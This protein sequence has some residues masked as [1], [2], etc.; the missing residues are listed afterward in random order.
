MRILF[1]TI[2]S[3]IFTLTTT[4]QLTLTYEALP[5]PGD[6]FVMWYDTNPN[7]DIGEA[8]P[9]EQHFDFS[10]LQNS[11][12][13]YSAY[14][15][16]AD[17]EVQPFFPSSNLY[18]YGPAI[19]YGGPGTPLPGY[20]EGWMLF[21]T[22]ETGMWV[23][24]YKIDD[25]NYPAIPQTPA[26]QL[27]RTPCTYNDVFEQNSEWTADFN[28]DSSDADTV[29][30]SFVYSKLSVDAWGT[31]DTPIEED[32]A[33]LRINEYRETIDSVYYR[34][35]GVT[36]WKDEFKRDT[37]NVYSYYSTE[38][39]HPIVT[40]YCKPNDEVISAE[41]LQYSLLYN[42]IPKHS[43]ASYTVY[44]NPSSHSLQI[45]GLKE[46]TSYE[47]YNE[48]GKV[49]ISGEIQTGETIDISSLKAGLYHLSIFNNNSSFSTKVIKQ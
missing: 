34:M 15:I 25:D 38:K 47:V 5:H 12:Q 19:L 13:K 21:R 29:Y 49:V 39:R 30:T 9:L 26:L 27:V 32:I 4:A 48:L 3:L 24:G 10:N 45:K 18:T 17:S 8:S 7:I 2:S 36:V 20:N 1:L 46:I 35:N 22:D 41:Y 14:G 44:P 16:T 28:F 23:E 6:T 33:V 31:I 37:N 40:V 42:S 43:Q 11:S